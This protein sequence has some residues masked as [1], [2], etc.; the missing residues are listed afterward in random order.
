LEYLIS[1]IGAT[2]LSTV[3]ILLPTVVHFL[4]YADYYKDK[5]YVA[6]GLFF[7]RSA[8]IVTIAVSAFVVGVTSGS[9]VG[10]DRTI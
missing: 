8:A 7:L 1:L 4:A 10:T 5:G 3:G 9:S 2:C 6:Y